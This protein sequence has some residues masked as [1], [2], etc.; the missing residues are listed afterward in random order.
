MRRFKFFVTACLLLACS[1]AFAKE[2]TKTLVTAQGDKVT[3]SYDVTRKNGK[4]VVK[5]VGSRLT[6]GEHG[7]KYSN[8]S[9]IVA[10]FFDRKGGY[11]DEF[12]G[13]VNTRPFTV[14]AGLQ[15]NNRS[16]DGYFCLPHTP[17]PS[18]SFE[19]TTT[20]AIALI[21]PLYLAKHKKRGEYEVFQYCGD[22]DISIAPE[23][24]PRPQNGKKEQ[25]SSTVEYVEEE[26]GTD[27]DA[28]AELLITKVKTML[29]Y[30]DNTSF[31][32][33]LINQISELK[34]LKSK[35]SS[36]K[37][38]QEIE[39][40][41]ESCDAKREELNK[42]AEEQEVIEKQK[43]AEAMDDAEFR[44]CRTIEDYEHYL[45]NNPD[46][47]HRSEAEAEKADLEG[48]K[49][50]QEDKQH[51]R[52][53]WMIIGGALLAILL[54]VG[55]QV[56]QS[57]R[58]IKTQRSIMQMQKD[59]AGQAAGTAKRRA[60]SLI[61]NKTHT[62]MN[63]T[64]NKGRDLMQ[65]GVQKTKGAAKKGGKESAA[66]AAAKP[67]TMNKLGNNNKQISI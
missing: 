61:R 2:E 65:K 5:F 16:E 17:P 15:Y 67:K 27:N 25:A 55:N 49:K 45:K 4:I 18:L 63:A 30:Q 51:K 23:N 64:R 39:Q 52:T 66:S 57:F 33:E 8:P 3:V 43:A 38:R 44:N 48:Q 56:M 11:S 32:P 13:K 50:A 54:F 14:P 20:D 28:L 12:I 41:L 24:T 29:D 22:I 1:I 37:L 34:Q 10:L 46:G 26:V 42:K 60:K 19:S 58:N 31:S 36:A 9:E 35:V 21:I 59:V 47:K 6:L 40:V 53:V 62:A 7:G